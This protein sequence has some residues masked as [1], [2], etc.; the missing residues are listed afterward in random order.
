MHFLAWVE[1]THLSEWIRD[2]DSVLAYPGI[3]F[4]HTLGMSVL[5]GIAFVVDVA[6]LRWNGVKAL[7]P[8]VALYPYIWLGFWINAGTGTLLLIAD[9]TT[10]MTN[11]V[12]YIKMTC[13]FLGVITVVVMRRR[14]ERETPE[15]T[16]P[17]LKR[18]AVLS[19][20][21]WT[22]AITA[23]RLMAYLGPVSG[24]SGLKK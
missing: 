17:A 15:G 23:G 4:M 8:L 10:K 22:C 11:P 9:A 12:F 16:G 3:L 21:L 14:L 24:L 18:L 1:S 5:V 2:S 20:L 6:V 7:A 19:L 13:V